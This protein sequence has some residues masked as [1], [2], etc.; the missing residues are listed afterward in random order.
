M[1]PYSKKLEMELVSQALRD[2]IQKVVVGG[3]ILDKNKESVLLLK[4]HPSDFMPNIEELP[5][6]GVHEGESLAEAL[7]RE[8]QEE[9]TLEVELVQS[10][11]S[12]FDYHSQS[13]RLT[14]QFNF[15][16]LP[17]LYEPIVLIPEEH[18]SY[19]W[20]ELNNT[21]GLSQKMREIF[22]IT[23]EAKNTGSLL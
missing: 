18:S 21:A 8:V 10:Y 9:T 2:D 23:A 15:L 19:L 12:S 6:G 20:K 5:S 4:R 17:K 7:V 1:R 3:V 22:E 13:G 14:R 16:V 11:I